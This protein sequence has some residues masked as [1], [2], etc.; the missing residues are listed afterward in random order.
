MTNESRLLAVKLVHTAVWA[1][2]AGCIV[3]I[4]IV[5]ACGALP[6][7]AALCAVVMGEVV[8][9]LLNRWSCPLTAVAAR[10][11]TDRRD[12]FDIFLPEWL[13]RHNK[14]IFGA[15]YVVGLL[16]VLALWLR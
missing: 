13:A 12:N 9:L 1:V 2:F 3:A 4:P 10:Y 11:T 14:T 7:A 15:L 16:I 8:V 6:L 5:A